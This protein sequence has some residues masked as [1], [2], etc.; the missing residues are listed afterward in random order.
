MKV[1]F[2]DSVHPVLW[3]ELEKLNCN[4]VD[5]TTL[6][7]HEI[8]PFVHDLEGIV[9]RSKFKITAEFLEN[10]PNL[11]FIARSGSGLENIDLDA[12]KT[13]NIAVINSPEGNK[14]AVAEHLIGMLLLLLNGL[15][16]ADNE[17]RN[18]IWQREANR[19]IEL[20]SLT[21][22]IIGYGVVGQCVAQTLKSFGCTVLA[23]DKYKKNYGDEFAQEVTWEQFCKQVDIVSLH[24]N[25]L[26]QNHHMANSAFFNSFAKPIYFINTARGNCLNT[27][28]LNEALYSK[29]VIGACLDV[30]EFEM[31]DFENDLNSPIL[32][33]LFSFDNV[34][35]SPHV[36][37]WTT[38][39]YY[40]LSWYLA[41]KIKTQFFNL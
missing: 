5:F 34:V 29:K 25:Y 11:K 16:K 37:G 24:V 4:C 39:S 18:K 35:F 13:K 15:K 14:N 38:Q 22:G 19:G 2:I 32:N 30:L 17:V 9:I 21:F 7:H 8:L 36:A 20:G 41:Q 3:E 6:K 12:A 28:D 33:N 40:K 1:G 31:V 26:P 27:N 10:C 23:Y